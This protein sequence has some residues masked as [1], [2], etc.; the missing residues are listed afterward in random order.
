MKSIDSIDFTWAQLGRIKTVESIGSIDS[1]DSNGPNCVRELGPDW[2]QL[3]FPIGLILVFTLADGQCENKGILKWLGQPG[4]MPWLLL[5]PPTDFLV[6]VLGP[7]KEGPGP[8]WAQVGLIRSIESVGSSGS[9][10]LIGSIVS[11]DIG[12]GWV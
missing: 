9:I 1:I 8:N 10:G 3:L 11:I 2:V 12:P 4:L 5:A 7:I 6:S